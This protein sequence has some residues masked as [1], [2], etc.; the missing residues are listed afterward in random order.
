[1]PEN[2]RR[3]YMPGTTHGGGRGGFAVA[4]EPDARCALP[5]NPNPM[6]DTLGALTVALVDWVVRGTPPPPSKYPTLAD[7]TLAPATRAALG[8]PQV[9][10]LPFADDLVNVVLDYDFGPDFIYNDMSG[11]ITRQPPA[12]K[13]LIPTLVPRVNADGNEIAGV[14]SVLHEAPLGTYLGW[15]IQA[16]GFFAGQICGFAGG[17]VSFART[18][19]DRLKGGDPRLSLEERYGTQE[20]YACVARRAAEALAR[21]RFLLKPDADRLIAE[22]ARS[23]ILPSNAESDA[24]HR[25]RADSLCR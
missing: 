23:R 19:A 17:Y 24:E 22:A 21:D 6:S 11:V 5:R 9:P 2:V 16:S 7:R 20:G 15:N 18:R 1:L 8:F 4:S 25:R 3:Y 13:R 12:V 14:A 10:G